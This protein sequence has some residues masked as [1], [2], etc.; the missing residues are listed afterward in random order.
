MGDIGDQVTKL[1]DETRVSTY[2]GRALNAPSRERCATR[3]RL[4][5]VTASSLRLHNERNR[6]P[7]A[8][9]HARLRGE[10]P[11]PVVTRG[12]VIGLAS[13]KNVSCSDRVA[14]ICFIEV[15]RPCDERDDFL[16]AEAVP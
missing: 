9:R 12:L 3:L 11:L 14:R 15:P 16:V 7:L 13:E 4:Q 6:T 8:N 1:L 2:L 10:E 5:R